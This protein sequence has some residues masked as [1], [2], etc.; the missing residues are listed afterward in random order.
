MCSFVVGS[1]LIFYF[2][3]RKQIKWVEKNVQVLLLSC[4]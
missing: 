2:L 1:L 3:N 4:V